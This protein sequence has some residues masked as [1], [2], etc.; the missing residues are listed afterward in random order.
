MNIGKKV[1][2]T[3]LKGIFI[4]SLLLFQATV[5]GNVTASLM[6][7][8]INEKNKKK[9]LVLPPVLVIAPT[10]DFDENSNAIVLDANATDDFDSENN[11]L[12]YSLTGTDDDAF[13]SI[14]S[15]GELSFLTPPDFESPQDGGMDN[16][17]IVT[18]TVTDSESLSASQPVVVTIN[19]VDEDNDGFTVN[20]G[21]TDDM[22]PCVPDNSANLCCEAVA[23]TITQN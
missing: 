21:E 10:A 13:F 14:N 15:D 17:Y 11:G 18:I 20:N 6:H 22:N 23:P 19:D 12:T 1:V 2:L 5:N 7:K 8:K 4:I 16:T 9:A 3:T